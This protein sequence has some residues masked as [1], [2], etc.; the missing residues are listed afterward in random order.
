MKA[1]PLRYGYGYKSQVVV[2]SI[3]VRSTFQNK[4]VIS[5]VMGRSLVQSSV[6]RV[7]NQAGSGVVVMGDFSEA[8]AVLQEDLGSATQCRA[9]RQ[10]SYAMHSI[11]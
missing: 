11:L 10:G 2:T 1:C 4:I 9:P 3:K 5:R 8:R 6:P 7:E